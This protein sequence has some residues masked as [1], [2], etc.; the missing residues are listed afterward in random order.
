MSKPPL[1]TVFV[2]VGNVLYPG[3]ATLGSFPV[4]DVYKLAEVA[5]GCR[6]LDRLIGDQE[7]RL[8]VH[9]YLGVEPNVYNGI[10]TTTFF[11]KFVARTQA[12]DGV[13]LH[14]LRNRRRETRCRNCG[15]AT[16][17]LGEK[18]VG[19]TIALDMYEKA[20]ISDV[21]ILVSGDADLIP[22]VQRVK[23]QGT[24]VVI[25]AWASKNTSDMLASLS[26]VDPLFL[27]DYHN[28]FLA[29]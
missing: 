5:V 8:D 12:Q 20:A 6:R 29:E 9:A 24:P 17:K 2:N 3:R 26:D 27:K 4:I 16:S 14:L 13:T 28:N 18:G 15:H 7:V 1:V 11:G 22:A 10:D 25:A 23:D 21:I 19:V